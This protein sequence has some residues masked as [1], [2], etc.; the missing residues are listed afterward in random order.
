MLAKIKNLPNQSIL[1]ALI[2]ADLM[3]IFLHI[4][5]LLPSEIMPLFQDS[6]FAINTDN[7]LAESFQYVQELWITLTLFWLVFHYRQR[8]MT[9]FGLLFAYFL[10]DDMITIHEF[11]GWKVAGIFE[12]LPILESF[13]NLR[14][15]DF[16]ELLI[17][18]IAGLIIFA[19][20]FIFYF[21]S[22]QPIRQIFHEIFA[23]LFIFLLFGVGLDLFD[24]LFNSKVTP[25]QEAAVNKLK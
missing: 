24:R 1:L 15:K 5:Y 25:L 14:A 11:L 2:A 22:K 9:G 23:L 8:A 4:L 10:L 3:Y 16:G 19:F 12:D 7:G 13:T 6:A 20:I 18:S 17:S 21:R